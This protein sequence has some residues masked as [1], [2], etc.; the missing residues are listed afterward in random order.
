MA[1][2][3]FTGYTILD[4]NGKPL[5]TIVDVDDSTENVLFEVDNEGTQFYV[6]VVEDFI[7]AIDEDNRTLTMN[8]PEGLVSAQTE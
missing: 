4:E 1:C 6:P 5:G 2:D 8:L 7:L 3:Y